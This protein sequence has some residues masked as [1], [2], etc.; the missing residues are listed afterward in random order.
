[1]YTLSHS[2][3]SSQRENTWDFQRSHALVEVTAQAQQPPETL[4]AWICESIDTRFPEVHP[5]RD[6]GYSVTALAT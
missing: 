5:D 1:M 2:L 3:V 6:S 4:Q